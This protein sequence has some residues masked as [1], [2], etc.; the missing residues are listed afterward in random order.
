[1]SGAVRT[2]TRDIARAAIRFELAQ[3]AF[4]LF[5]R[6]G[7]DNVTVNDL[8]AAAGVSRSTFLRYFGSKEDAVLGAV[9]AQGEQVAD[10]LRA[11]PADE[12]DWTALRRALDAVTEVHRRDPDGALAMSQLIMRT[13]ALGV[14]TLEKQNGW[15]PAI[16]QA[17]AERA[18]PSWPSLLVP[19]VRAAAAVDCLNV[20]VD[21]WTA[22]DGRLDLDA[23]LD[24]AFA[25]FAL[26]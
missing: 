24:E 16:A 17:L 15:R 23:L 12:G 19:L 14:R 4:D 2:N 18:D 5:R 1:M 10:A 20:A 6:E 7:F 8:A 25:A 22:S 9:D 21:R 26:R 3:V 13:P 11:R